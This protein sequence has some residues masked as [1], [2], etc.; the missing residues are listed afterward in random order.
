VIDDSARGGD[1]DLLVETPDP[2]DQPALAAARLA[3]NI[4]RRLGGRRVDVVLVTPETAPLP[5][6]DIARHRGVTL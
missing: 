2:V 3:A 5:I 6:H 4:E 1:V